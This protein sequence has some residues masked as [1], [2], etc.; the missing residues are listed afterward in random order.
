MKD[1]VQELRVMRAELRKAGRGIEAMV[2]QRAID[3]LQR[4]IKKE[5]QQGKA[6]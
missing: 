5:N 4:R 1:A 3:R 6:E 2:I